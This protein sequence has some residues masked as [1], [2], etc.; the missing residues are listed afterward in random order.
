MATKKAKSA[1]EIAEAAKT[2]R[3]LKPH[4]R[5]TT[6]F[7]DDNHI[8]VDAEIYVLEHPEMDADEIYSHGWTSDQESAA[9]KAPP[10]KHGHGSTA[11]KKGD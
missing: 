4:I 8:L 6:A 5:K 2:L 9:K 7:G 1:K 10:W 11:K 3:E